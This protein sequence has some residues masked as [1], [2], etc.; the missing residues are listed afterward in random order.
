M[1]KTQCNYS[2]I[3]MEYRLNRDEIPADFIII[4]EMFYKRNSDE[5]S[6]GNPQ[7]SGGILVDIYNRKL[8]LRNHN[9]WIRRMIR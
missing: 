8:S 6:S 7:Y 9:Y 3:F 4:Q 2:G 1:L 5:S